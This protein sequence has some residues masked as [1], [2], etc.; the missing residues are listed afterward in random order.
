MDIHNKRNSNMKEPS[1]NT[2]AICKKKYH[3]KFHN[4]SHLL[5]Y[6]E[7]TNQFDFESQLTTK[8]H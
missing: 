1:T 4:D 6:Q 3:N 7:L 5:H 2:Q 8:S